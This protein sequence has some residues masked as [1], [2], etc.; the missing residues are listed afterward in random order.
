M[1]KDEM[2]QLVRKIV[3]R[4]HDE[5]SLAY[6]RKLL[7]SKFNLEK[8]VRRAMAEKLPSADTPEIRRPES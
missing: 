8:A 3:E 6:T 2:D 5:M 1:K 4:V 7:P